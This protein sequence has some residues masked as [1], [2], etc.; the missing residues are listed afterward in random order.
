MSGVLQDRGKQNEGY[1]SPDEDGEMVVA[2]E[3]TLSKGIASGVVVLSEGEG[4]DVCVTLCFLEDE[5]G[6]EVI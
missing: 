3:K 2:D 1:Y 6:N 5:E 4:D